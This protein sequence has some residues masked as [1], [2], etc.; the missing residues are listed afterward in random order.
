[1]W[2]AANDAHKKEKL[3]MFPPPS[4]IDL[5]VTMKQLDIQRDSAM[6][7]Y[8][9]HMPSETYGQSTRRALGRLV[10][11]AKSVFGQSS[12]VKGQSSSGSMA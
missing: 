2:P 6:D 12:K 9:D 4:H 1:V 10:G 3:D 11:A 8:L 7:S 5:A